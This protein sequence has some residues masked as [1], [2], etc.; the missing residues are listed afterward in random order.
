MAEVMNVTAGIRRFG[1][2]ALDLA[3]VAAGRFDA[4]W[5]RSLQAWDIAAGIVLVRE[6]GGVITDLRGGAEMLTQGTVLTANENLHPQLLKL[7]KGV[8]AA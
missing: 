8:K 7:L 6:A 4:F 1:S 3:Y 5:E 2:A